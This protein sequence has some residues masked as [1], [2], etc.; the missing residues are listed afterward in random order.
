MRL[1]D[2]DA[3]LKEELL[4]IQAMTN[5][6]LEK[7][8]EQARNDTKNVIDEYDAPVRHGF[9]RIYPDVCVCG[10]CDEQSPGIFKYCPN[11]GALMDMEA[12]EGW[13]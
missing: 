9:W 10:E 7:L 1:G 12:K 13:E 6:E 4:S 3:Q 11:C 5:E 8:I 2:L